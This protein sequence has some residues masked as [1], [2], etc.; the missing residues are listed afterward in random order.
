MYS[1]FLRE[2]ALK[3]WSK[4]DRSLMPRQPSLKRV[5]LEPR[6]SDL[7]RWERMAKAGS[8][9][10]KWGKTRSQVKVKRRRWIRL[11]YPLKSLLCSGINANICKSLSGTLEAEALLSGPFQVGRSF[12]GREWIK[13]Q[14]GKGCF[15]VVPKQRLIKYRICDVALLVATGTLG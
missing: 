3:P 14:P 13:M 11:H 6:V 8:E 9:I 2:R 5:T 15:N 12:C 1:N 4:T 7:R 10:D